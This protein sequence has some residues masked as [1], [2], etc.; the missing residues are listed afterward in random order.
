[1][2]VDTIPIEVYRLGYRLLEL[3]SRIPSSLFNGDTHRK[4]GWGDE[5]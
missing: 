5:L 3:A 4:R 2:G 1:M